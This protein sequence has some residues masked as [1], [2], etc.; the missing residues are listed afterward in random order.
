METAYDGDS[1]CECDDKCKLECFAFIDATIY[2]DEDW[3]YPFM[4]R[5]G[6]GGIPIPNAIGVYG[7][8]QAHI[9]ARNE[10][11]EYKLNQ[12]VKDIP[13]DHQSK[14]ECESDRSK[15]EQAMERII[16]RLRSGTLSPSHPSDPRRPPMDPLWPGKNRP[17]FDGIPM[18][19][20]HNSQ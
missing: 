18:A 20:M 13:T 5:I 16:S 19:P 11:V 12:A 3:K 6:R 14:K 15:A 9:R 8:E 4:R 1:W 7:H 17:P 2:E 10:E